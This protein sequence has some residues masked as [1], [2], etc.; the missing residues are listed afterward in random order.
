MFGS[1]GKKIGKILG[2]L[3]TAALACSL[4]HAN[5]TALPDP[6]YYAPLADHQKATPQ[7]IV[8]A[9]GCFWGI[10]AVFQHVKGVSKAISGYAGGDA[11]TAQYNIVST[12]VTHHAEAVEITYDPS[13]ITLGK[14]LKVFFSVAHD[15]TELNRQGPDH[16]TQYRSAIFTST[17]EQKKIAENY[18]AQLEQAKVFKDAIVTQIEPL[19]QF[20]PAEDYHQDYAKLHP[21]NPYIMIND[22]P[23]VTNLESTYPD[24]YIKP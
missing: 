9:G 5:A 10:Q 12:G 16:G 13:Q 19:T 3:P 21:E 11:L 14:I 17:A 24:L 18:I 6:L 15:P 1:S 8:V 22:S 4:S 20:Y 23:K 7:S 2:L